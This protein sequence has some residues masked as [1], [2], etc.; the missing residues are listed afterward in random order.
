MGKDF[1]IT[2]D[3]DFKT[4]IHVNRFVAAPFLEWKTTCQTEAFLPSA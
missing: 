2:P 3:G 1:S 4:H